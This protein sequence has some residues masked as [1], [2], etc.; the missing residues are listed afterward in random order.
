MPVPCVQVKSL[1]GPLLACLTTSRSAFDAMLKQHSPDGTR[2]ALVEAIHANPGG[3]EGEAYRCEVAAICCMFK[4]PQL[5]PIEWACARRWWRRSML[6]PAATRARRTVKNSCDLL[7]L[8]T[9]FQLS[10]IE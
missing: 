7:H 1:Y 8:S 2:K 3:H 9:M 6:T 10:P 4:M 5:S